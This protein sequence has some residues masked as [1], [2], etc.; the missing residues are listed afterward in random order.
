MREV[1]LASNLSLFLF[2]NEDKAYLLDCNFKMVATLEVPHKEGWEKVNRKSTDQ[3][4]DNKVKEYQNILGLP[5]GGS[6]EEI[7]SSFRKLA[8]RY[9]PD[10]N[11]NNTF[12]D[13]RMKE[14]IAAYEYLTDEEAKDAFRGV[15]DE[16]YWINT[17]DT[18]KFEA[19]GLNFTISFLIGS[20]GED[21]IYGSGI[22]DE[23]SRIYLGCYSGKTYQVNRNGVAEKI[24][25]IPEDEE[26]LYGHSNPVSFIF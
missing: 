14:I 10:V 5:N 6:L 13:S 20:S 17:I 7:K 16:E 22:S 3:P 1:D 12:A 19:G 18:F 24:F 26:A 23:A 2:T 9:H 8:F 4:I 15:E 21:W 25:V 11:P